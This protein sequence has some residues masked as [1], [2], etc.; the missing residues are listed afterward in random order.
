[1]VDEHNALIR[2]S[3]LVLNA[4]FRSLNFKKKELTVF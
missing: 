2:P 3:D 4:F 1:M